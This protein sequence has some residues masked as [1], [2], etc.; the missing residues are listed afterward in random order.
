MVSPPKPWEVARAP[1]ATSSAPTTSTTMVAPV[2]T[3]AASSVP[4]VPARPSNFGAST[5]TADATQN[6]GVMQRPGYGGSTYQ[7]FGSSLYGGGGY[8]GSGFGSMYGGG[9]GSSL[10]GGGGYG[11]YGSSMYGG[12]MYGGYGSS[13]YGMQQPMYGPDGQPMAHPTFAQQLESSTGQTFALLQAIVGT[14]GGLAHMLESTLMATHSSFFAMVG[15]ADQ[16]S[17]L[18]Q[19]LGTVFGLFGLV[20]WLR[21]RL[22]PRPGDDLR[23]DRKPLVVF[24]LAVLGLPYAMHRL[25]RYL[26]ARLPPNQSAQ[27]LD[28]SQLA[29]GRVLHS[30]AARDALELSLQP[31]D[32]V[33]VVNQGDGNG[34]WWMGRMRDGRE[35]WFPRAFVEV[36]RPAGATQPQARIEPAPA[37]TPEPKK[38][39]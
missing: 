30:F 13:M 14:F 23:R 36:I 28:P 19:S 5:S 12:S 24:L 16:L 35:G 18:R 27:P 20:S 21:R 2:P 1:V 6:F 25:V 11:G 34:E 38:V 3:P 29:F 32:I 37:P 39:D 4:D 17:N 8:G 22:F 26:S 31:G 33:A 7:P 10:Y 9:Y 15:V